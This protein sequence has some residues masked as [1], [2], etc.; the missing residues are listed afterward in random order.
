MAEKS[1]S[2]ILLKELAYPSERL[3]ESSMSAPTYPRLPVKGGEGAEG[4]EL[5]TQHVRQC[6]GVQQIVHLL[7][8]HP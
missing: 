1:G 2:R 8:A 5:P 6:I 4:D 3:T 7:S